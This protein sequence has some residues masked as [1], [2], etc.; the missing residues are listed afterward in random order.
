VS[1]SVAGLGGFSG[2]VGA[3]GRLWRPFARPAIGSVGDLLGRDDEARLVL[4]LAAGSGVLTGQ[5]VRAGVGLVALEGR[6]DACR[7]LGRALPGVPVVTVQGGPLP[8]RDAA[9]AGVVADLGRWAGGPSLSAEV[10]RVLE[11]GGCL[12]LVE[13][14]LRGDLG[15]GDEGGGPG[16]RDDSTTST[17]AGALDHSVVDRFAEPLVA[18]HPYR[19]SD[20]SQRLTIVRV[21]VRLP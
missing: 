6:A 7:Q 9:V 11:P 3:Q 19:G 10:H 17:T 13:D 21:W 14:T 12:V 18:N 15:V 20:G 8:I 5:L 1:D 4:E 16:G 2:A